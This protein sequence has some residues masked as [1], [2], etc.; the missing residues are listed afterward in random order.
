MKKPYLVLG[1]LFLNTDNQS[2]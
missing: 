2:A 1:E